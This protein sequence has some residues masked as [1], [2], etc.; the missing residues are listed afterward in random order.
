LRSKH[1]FHTPVIEFTTKL[2]KKDRPLSYREAQAIAGLAGDEF[3]ELRQRVTLIALLARELCHQAG[4]ELI[5]GKVEFAFGARQNSGQRELILMDS[6][7]PD[8]MRLIYGESDLSKEFLRQ[9]YRQTSWY[10]EWIR[11]EREKTPE[12]LPTDIKIKA[13]EN[14]QLLRRRLCRPEELRGANR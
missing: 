2:E 12:Q 3:Q 13:E 8:E 1:E 7:G 6:L 5:D 9:H 11:G 14:Y 10:G 4:I